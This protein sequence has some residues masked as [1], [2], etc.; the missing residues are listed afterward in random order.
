[1]QVLF[2]VT[3]MAFFVA[4][5]AVVAVYGG[6]T[7]RYLVAWALLAGAVSQFIGQDMTPLEPY[8]RY[9]SIALAYAAIV[10]SAA[11]MIVWEG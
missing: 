11:A 5:A 10:L 2:A 7:S 9:I 1:M 4:F 6:S 3:A 8:A